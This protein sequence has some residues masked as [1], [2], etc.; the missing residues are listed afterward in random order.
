MDLFDHHCPW[1]NNCVG[2]QNYRFF[3]GFV[4]C[5]FF[6]ATSFNVLGYAARAASAARAAATAL[7]P[8]RRRSF[9]YVNL[10]GSS[11]TSSWAN[12]MEMPAL[13]FFLWH[14][15]FYA[16]FA[17]ALVMQ[18]AS[19]IAG[20]LTTNETINKRR[21]AP[22]AAPLPARCAAHRARRYKYLKAADGSFAN[23]FNRGLAH[24]LMQFVGCARMHACPRM[25]ARL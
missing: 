11:R 10:V 5:A 2:A 3:I 7:M 16:L 15:M 4:V 1:I 21:C 20:N 9:T 19:L 22:R 25:H 23:P 12:Y 24:N 6:S 17:L 18:H 13:S 14:Y 8:A